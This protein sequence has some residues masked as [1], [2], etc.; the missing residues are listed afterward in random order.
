MLLNRQSPLGLIITSEPA[1]AATSEMGLSALP[2]H[3]SSSSVWLNDPY[4]GFVVL[5]EPSTTE[6]IPPIGLDPVNVPS[7][8]PRAAVHNLAVV[9]GPGS[10]IAF[11]ENVEDLVSKELCN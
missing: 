5:C 9:R 1:A 6:H 3:Q 4:C 7:T 8:S 10:T 11:N 2:P